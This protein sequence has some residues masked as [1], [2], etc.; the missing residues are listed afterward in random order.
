MEKNPF[1]QM[2]DKFQRLN[3]EQSE[4]ADL[5]QWSFKASDTKAAYDLSL[6]LEELTERSVLL[7]RSLPAYTGNPRSVHD[8]EAVIGREIPVEIGFTEE[9]WFSLR[10]PLLLPKKEHGSANYIRSIVYP[11]MEGFF[12]DKPPVRFRD[13]VLIYRHL[14]SRNRPERQRRDHDNIEVNMLSDTI[15]LYVMPDDGPE[16]CCHYYCSAAAQTERTEVYVVPQTD[17]PYW[18]ESEK[19]DAGGGGETL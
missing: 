6:R 5:V 16:I 9:G 4:L 19:K 18:F 15:A 10:M 2:L 3:K 12:R 1:L 8:V 14:Y 13:C 11:A 7:S 17:F